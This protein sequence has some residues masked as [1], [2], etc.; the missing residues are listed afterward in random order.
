M[1]CAAYIIDKWFENVYLFC[2]ACVG[3]GE[4]VVVVVKVQLL[5]DEGKLLFS[6]VVGNLPLLSSVVVFLQGGSVT[7]AVVGK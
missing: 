5:K 6:Q 4:G 2:A 3:S 7:A 1:M